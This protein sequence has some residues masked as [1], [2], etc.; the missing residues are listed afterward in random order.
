MFQSL[1]ILILNPPILFHYVKQ[2]LLFGGQKGYF[3]GLSVLNAGLNVDEIV[4]Y[5]AAFVS[6]IE[7]RP[8]FRVF[9]A[10]SERPRK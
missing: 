3:F 2:F 1:V 5:C 6:F 10:L 9:S 4:G 7:K 8:L